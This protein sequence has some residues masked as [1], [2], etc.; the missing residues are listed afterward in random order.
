MGYIVYVHINKING[1]R[2]YGITSRKP[3]CRWGKNGNGY[4]SN[5]HFTNAINKYGWIN[6]EHIIVARGLS[7]EEAKWL[8][9]QLIK[10]WNTNDP[11]KGYNNSLGGEGTK[12]FNPRK[13][14]RDTTKCSKEDGMN[15]ELLLQYGLI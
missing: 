12:G 9:I 10:E 5:E 4:K 15:M 11:N 2:Y 8:E 7:E 14:Q 13:K 1:K 3:E 6:F